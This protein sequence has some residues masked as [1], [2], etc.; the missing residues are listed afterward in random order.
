MLLL[1]LSVMTSLVLYPSAA[2]LETIGTD[3]SRTIVLDMNAHDAFE[4]A[5]SAGT[6]SIAF[7]ADSNVD[8]YV[9]SASDYS[10][11]TDPNSSSF[12]VQDSAEDTQSFSFS[13]AQS[14]M[15]FVVDNDDVSLSGA[16]PT[17]PVSYVLSIRFAGGPT[18]LSIALA[19]V[20][21][22]A[23][24]SAIGVVLVRA[25]RRRAM[26][27][28]SPAQPAPPT[29]I[30]PPP[31]DFPPLASPVT[32]LFGTTRRPMAPHEQDL[33]LRDFKNQRVRMIVGSTVGL[34]L[35]I[36]YNVFPNLMTLGLSIIA[37]IT[38]AIVAPMVKVRRAILEGQMMEM[39]GPLAVVGRKQGFYRV[40]FGTESVWVSA[41]LYGRMA[42]NQ[43]NS[44]TVLPGADVAVAVNGV[45]LAKTE[46]VR[47]DRG[48]RT[49][50]G[51]S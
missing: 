42:P 37:F 4:V 10:E 19:I 7:T 30:P 20:A 5:I 51:W 12:S 25:R 22:V 1:S 34:V 48:T 38:P 46:R 43:T 2:A 23:V 36:A 41:S 3:A 35:A 16:S 47:L 44:L 15:I 50:A 45:P 33:L 32:Q 8:F 39:S 40:Q 29:G 6:A 28:A 14:G 11:Y 26:Q 18:N 17:G 13:T 31:D 21:G 9:L 27:P 24:F 49:S